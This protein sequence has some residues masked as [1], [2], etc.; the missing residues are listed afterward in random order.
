MLT[1]STK[2]NTTKDVRSLVVSPSLITKE[3]GLPMMNFI[4]RSSNEPEHYRGVTLSK[5]QVKILYDE[6]GAW[7]NPEDK[8]DEKVITEIGILTYRVSGSL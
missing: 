4:T 2:N 7:L 1:L 5:E 8:K 3:N 6:L